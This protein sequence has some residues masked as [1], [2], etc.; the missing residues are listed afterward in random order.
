MKPVG[1]IGVGSMGQHHARVYQEL[2]DVDLVGVYDVDANRARTIANKYGA[3][4][5][6]LDGLVGSV[7]ALS[8]V[9]PTTHHRELAEKAIDAGT[10][11]LVEK[12]LAV[13]TT[14]AEAIVEQADAAD[15]TLQVGHIER[16]NPAV[17]S[18]SQFVD[19]LDIIALE[20]ERQG[21][22]VDRGGDDS[23]LMDLMIHDIDITCSL[24]TGDVV[25]I[26]ATGTADGDYI[27]TALT[28]EN[29]VVA[30]LTAS[31]VT[32]K[33]VRTLSLTADECRVDVNYTSQDVTITHQTK[34]EY[35][36]ADG[37]LRFRSESVTERPTVDNGEPLKKELSSFIDAS[38]TDVDPVVT[39]EDGLQAIR[40]AERI[41]EPLESGST[42]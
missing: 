8:I 23:V 21:P 35:I 3:K 39:G 17:R 14:D 19:D 5:L 11:I 18:L 32:A 33:K 7:D 38:M 27:T 13:S 1:V 41:Q 22:P 15:V 4:P 6:S 28:F 16:Y 42:H 20:A 40:L 34:P 2:P 31:R 12:P 25:D 24:L 29:G 37:G 10:D 30:T 36:E 26:E 9:T